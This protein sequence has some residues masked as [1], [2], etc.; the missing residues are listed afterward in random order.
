MLDGC[1]AS[2]AVQQLPLDDYEIVIVDNG[3]SEETRRVVERWMRRL[4]NVRLEF[5]P[6]RGVCRARNRGI[7]S[8]R[9]TI[10]AF[11][12]DDVLASEGWLAALV[13][14]Y[15]RWPGV[16]TI[17]GPIRLDWRGA[18][19]RW[20]PPDLDHWFSALDLGDQPRLLDDS[21]AVFSGN[22]SMLR[23]VVTNVGGFATRLGR[24]GK[25]LISNE[26]PELLSR[27][28][29]A[30]YGVGYE[31]D[32]SVVHQ[33]LESRLSPLWLIRRVYAQGRSDVILKRVRGEGEG[34]NFPTR[35][36]AVRMLF[37]AAFRGWRHFVR[38]FPTSD[39]KAGLV[40]AQGIR[41]AEV[42]GFARE[43]LL[44]SATASRGR[45]TER[46]GCSSVK[47]AEA[48]CEHTSVR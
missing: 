14:A 22:M 25:N 47:L 33:V 44:P 8:A 17:G 39:N 27:F 41:R 9:G 1:I 18:R 38:R 42:L 26:E 16:G 11:L 4:P 10:L 30:D 36:E 32:A 20:L 2:L 45:H 21:E 48:L 37:E 35:T 28:R 23:E 40:I 34:E 43:V 24:K 13:R 3:S 19:P 7:R 29:E 12:D 31:P 15:E 46:R 5:E 6:I